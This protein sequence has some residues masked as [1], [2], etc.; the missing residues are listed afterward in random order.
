MQKVVVRLLGIAAVQALT[1]LLVWHFCGGRRRIDHPISQ[2]ESGEVSSAE[3]TPK[4]VKEV[5]S[6]LP[7]SQGI[8]VRSGPL[9]HSDLRQLSLQHGGG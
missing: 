1:V 3:S 2:T 7:V 4:V 8:P 9:R 5:G 6:E